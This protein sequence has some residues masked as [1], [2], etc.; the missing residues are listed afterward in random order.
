MKITFNKS[1]RDFH[2]AVNLAVNNYFESS[3]IDKKASGYMWF[4]TAFF[5]TAV[6]ISYIGIM[7]NAGSM[8]LFFMSWIGLGLSSVFLVVNS[9]HDAV[10]G[11]YSNQNWMN[12]IMSKTFDLLGANSYIWGITHNVL[13]H[14]YTNIEGADEDIESLPFSRITESQPWKPHQ[15]YQQIYAFLLYTLGTLSWVFV[16]DYKKFSQKDLGNVKDK[17]HPAIQVL[18]LFFF[19]SLYYFVFIALPIM[20]SGFAWYW[21]VLGFVVGHMVEGFSIAT[22]FMLAHIVEKVEVL[23]PNEEGLME[24]NWAVHQMRTTAN[25]G[26]D[27]WL[28][29]FLTGGLNYQI[30]HHLFPTISHVHYP[31]IAN[32]VQSVAQ[33]HGV[34]YNEYPSYWEA[35]KSHYRLLKRLG[36]G[37]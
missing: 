3:K 15:R 31:A 24:D 30:E 36:Q 29:G 23:S 5:V 2:N 22:I 13:H 16:K 19:K 37:E 17:K 26:R 18:R 12:K 33:E 20:F 10:H 28:T 14:T 35:L 1:S 32:I 8:I 34:P 25:F 11:A 6:V 4:K 7:F 9:G 21:V 27:S